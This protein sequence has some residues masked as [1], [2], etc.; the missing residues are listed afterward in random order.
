MSQFNKQSRTII[1]IDTS[2]AYDSLIQYGR[3]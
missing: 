2:I 3:E 1:D